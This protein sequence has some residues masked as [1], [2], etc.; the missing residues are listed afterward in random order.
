[1]WRNLLQHE[2]QYGEASLPRVQ[3]EVC[4]DEETTH[5]ALAWDPDYSSLDMVCHK[6]G[7]PSTTYTDNSKLPQHIKDLMEVSQDC[8]IK[9]TDKPC[10]LVWAI[11]IASV[12]FICVVAQTIYLVLRRISTLQQKEQNNSRVD[13]DK[14]RK[15]YNNDETGFKEALGEMKTDLAELL[16]RESEINR[17]ETEKFFQQTVLNI[18]EKNN[19]EDMKKRILDLEK[20]AA[21]DKYK[22]CALQTKR[23]EDAEKIRKTIA[24]KDEEL[25]QLKRDNESFRK[26]LQQQC[27]LQAW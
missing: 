10:H 7:H 21:V 17:K 12:S 20:E 8:H 18:S 5:L 14:Q 15:L 2:L 26:Q 9:E 6:P 25:E 3:S 23:E 16:Q 4:L 22:M 19:C 24:L 11:V 27:Q 1:M 13:A